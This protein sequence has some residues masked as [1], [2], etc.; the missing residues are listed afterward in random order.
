MLILC[1]DHRLDP[2]LRHRVKS[3][4]RLGLTVNIYTDSRGDHFSAHTHNERHISKLSF[5]EMRIA[6]YIYLSGNRII[7][8]KL[9]Q[10]MLVRALGNTL[11][12]LEIPDLPLRSSTVLINKIVEKAFLAAIYV[13]TDRL[14]L[15]S[16]GF[17]SV[18][19]RKK[20]FV[21]IE[22]IN[23]EIVES[24][25]SESTAIID[26]GAR[27]GFFGV[28]RYFNQHR[29]LF[30]YSNDKGV[31]CI[32]HGGP[33][34]SEEILKKI[35]NQ[36]PLIEINGSYDSSELST[37]YRSIDVIYAVYD[38]EQTNVRLA[39]PNKLY[40]SI[41]YKKPIIVAK[42]TFLAELVE[43]YNIGIAVDSQD[44]D[45]FVKDMEALYLREF[46]FEIEIINEILR[47]NTRS[48]EQI[49]LV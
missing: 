26:R 11:V 29:L 27:I 35:R 17:L 48:L 42:G 18:V 9:L 19:G 20:P 12:V 6:K 2:R 3:I 31:K 34:K 16:G 45:S 30:R 1:A 13:A 4:Q 44:Y 43:R 38:A 24:Q 33:A 7:F 21:I 23:S 5:K 25:K 32:Y 46:N 47:E 49:L 22:N 41:I 36:N 37:L 15:T 28:Y 10:L 8:R 14:V 40:E 39:I